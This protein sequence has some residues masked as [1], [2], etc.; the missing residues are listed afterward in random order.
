MDEVRDAWCRVLDELEA[1]LVGVLVS[2]S[3]TTET[4]SSTETGSAT[5]SDEW[6]A[7]SGLG[8]IPGDLA[9]RARE[10]LGGQREL[11][12]ELE[13]AKREAGAQ[14]ATLRR[15]PGASAPAASVYLDVS[16]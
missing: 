13:A 3:S 2:T 11:I 7:P 12:A 14:L 6:I 1:E 4:S 5:G 10:L 8:P 16:G 9:Q 15:V